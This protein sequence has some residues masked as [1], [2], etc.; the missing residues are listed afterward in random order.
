M[1]RKMAGWNVRWRAGG[2]NTLVVVE[3]SRLG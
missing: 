1:I 2:D 3:V